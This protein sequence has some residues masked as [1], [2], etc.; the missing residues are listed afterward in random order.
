[1]VLEVPKE[2]E[3]KK[4]GL[5]GKKPD[6]TPQGPDPEVMSDIAQLTRRLR[7]LEEQYTNTRRRITVL[8][9]NML[10]HGKKLK[11]EIQVVNTDFTE[12]KKMIQDLEDKLVLVIKELKK[13]AK[14]EEVAVLNKY[15]NLWQPLDFVTRKEVEKII[16]EILEERSSKTT[17]TNK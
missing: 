14:K 9:Q 8:D 3:E 7:V 11:E 5:F 2:K 13:T 15:I 1:M 12:L 16:N 4:G 10:S 17:K 6:P